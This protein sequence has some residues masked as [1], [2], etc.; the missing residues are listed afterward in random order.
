MRMSHQYVY[1]F[2]GSTADGDATQKNLLG[3]K[4]ANLAEMCRVGLPVPAGFTLTT[5]VCNYFY[6][7]GKQYPPVLKQQVADAM[8]KTEEVM[9]ARFGD[10]K[11]PLLVS[12]RS[13]A[14]VSMPG[15]MDTV[16]NIGLN[17]TTLRGLIDKTGNERFAWD[18]Y[19]RFVQMYGDV[20]LDLKPQKKTDIDPFEH[21]MDELKEEKH[22]K[23]D[24]E[25]TTAD[26]QELVKR[27]KKAVKDRTGK[28]FPEEALD[29][30]WG[31]I[32]AVFGSWNNERAV[33]YR[34]QYGY[35]ADWGTAAN[36]CAMVFG[37]MGDDCAT[38]VAF[39]RDPATGEKVFYGEYLVNAQGEDV[40][41]GIRTPKKIAELQKEMPAVYKQLE[42]IREKLE[43]HYRDVQD[44]EF[45]VQKGKLWMLQTR[46]GKRT[47]FAAV[48]F[49]V[50]MVHEGLIT[51]EEAL[52]AGRVP[53]DDLNQLLQPVFDPAAKRKA[54]DSGKLLGKG[55]NAGPGAATGRIKFFADEAEEWV[56]KHGKGVVLVRRE[57]SPEDIRGMQAAD[58]IL[59]AFG[60][61][62]S[63][64]ALVSR[65]M[66][67]VC[68]VGCNALQIDYNARTVSVGGK[69][70]KDGDYI[71]IDGFTG[72]V[73]EGQ[74]ATKPSEIVQVLIEKS[75]K[76]EQS[77]VYQQFAELMGW[78]DGLRKLKVRTNADKPDQAEQ[79]VAF[80]AEGIGL[81]RTEHMFF[82][83]IDAMREMILAGSVEE[84][85]KA[86]EKLLPYQ[87]SDFEGL[88]KAMKGKP[89]TI[90]T[91]DPPLHE[92]LPHT[93][94][95]Q[96]DLANKL[97]LTVDEVM[98]RVH[99]LHEFNPMLGF[100][101]CRLGIVYPEITAMQARAIIE[102]ACNV[103][104]A[105]TDV[106]AEIMI[107]LVGFLPELKAQAKIVHDVAKDVFKEKGVEVNYLVGTMI[108]LPRACVVAD[109]IAK[110][111]QFFSFG[112]NDLTQTG[113]GMSRDDYGS[114]IRYY[115]EHDLVPKDPF[116]AIDIDGVGGLMKI[117]VERGRSVRPDLK[118]GICGEHGGEPDSV[119]FC[120]RIGLN[121]VS[122]S[123]FRVPIA[124]LAAAQAALE[125]K[126]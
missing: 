4:G 116:Q 85:K 89:V 72:E 73:M 103:K 84:R 97:G 25:L 27:F 61:A 38:G 18:S 20:V 105:G 29:Q 32:A 76:P 58:G 57:T 83:H 68:V 62:S 108:E 126:P 81:C 113:L 33:V 107:P 66:G 75:L 14:R 90:R 59:T 40:V 79:A 42:E 104:K 86:L 78:A 106:E 87:R 69:T 2:G 43:K 55:I 21:I 3:G 92:F 88:F 109:Q 124:R 98:S 91:L 12:C 71:S 60:G 9:G 117:G 39:T 1:F 34:R 23:L 48:R 114:Y 96:H 122:C 119:K 47:G 22:V 56:H 19:R 44:I 46:N 50:D 111:A 74:V 64:A 10:A 110:E 52:S 16:L 5:E 26:L 65:Q 53:P 93:K 36:I 123:P 101:G 112:T 77:K 63:H 35:P 118:V 100:R 37:N 8:R 102:A 99:A 30:M 24:T 120:H 94:A 82:D 95:E 7:H 80:G 121:Y 45:T 54:V 125:K 70:L 67:K 28:D 17:E 41:A 11:N 49:A 15:M 6:D 31:A 115:L 13:G 51:K